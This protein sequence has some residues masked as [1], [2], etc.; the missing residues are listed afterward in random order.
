MK[1]AI[2]GY[3][4]EGRATYDYARQ[5]WPAAEIVIADER[6]IADVPPG[7]VDVLTGPDAFAQLG[8]ADIV[9]RTPGLAPWRIETDGTVPRADHW[10]D[11]YKGQGHNGEPHRCYAASP[12]AHGP[13]GG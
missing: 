7:V 11:R 13:C 4:V 9:M 8:D 6:R 10:R 5:V 1:V 12:W 2:A 3:D